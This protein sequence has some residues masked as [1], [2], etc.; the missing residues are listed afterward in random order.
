SGQLGVAV[1]TA[2][3]AVGAYCP[4]ARARVGAVSSQSWCNPY[5]AYDGLDLMARGTGAQEACDKLLAADPKRE[6]R[7]IGFVDAIGGSAAYTGTACIPWCGHITG[8]NFAAQ[9]N[10]LMGAG[11]VEAMAETFQRTAPLALVER[12]IA[13]LE[14][15]QA[16]GGDSRGKQSASV[17]V[18]HIERY[19]LID[20][21]ADEHRNPI[22]ELRRIYEIAKYQSLPFIAQMPTRD[23]PLGSFGDDM[24][25]SMSVAPTYR[26]GGGGGLP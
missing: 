8:A 12:L 20:L 1:A 9:G 10:L 23:N 6:T 17:L 26:P 21:R 7:Q 5:L 22:N 13:A 25:W 16:Q 15:G 4:F 19:P 11:C 18:V 2:A 14:A 24:R 3:P